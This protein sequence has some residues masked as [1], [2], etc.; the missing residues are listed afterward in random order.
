LTRLRAGSSSTAL[1]EMTAIDKLL[2]IGSKALC[3]DRVPVFGESLMRDIAPRLTDE[4]HSIFIKK[5]GFLAFES[6]LLLFPTAT[7]ESI[8]SLA[9]WNSPAGWRRF[10]KAIPPEAIFFAEDVF[11]CQFGIGKET[12]LKLNP[13]SGNIDEHSACLEEWAGKILADYDAETGW[14]LA[15]EWQQT[16]GPLPLGHRLLGK[17]PFVLGGDYSLDNL[18]AVDGWVAMEK[19][20]YLFNQI[21]NVPDGNRVTVKGWIY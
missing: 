16:N 8:R 19:L 10:Y 1:Q 11:A 3:P 21:K 12:V 7:V 2:G 18:V 20:G 14:S 9:E 17:R 15:R 5:N 6:A 13:E 4:L